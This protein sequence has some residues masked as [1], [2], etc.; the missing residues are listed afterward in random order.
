MGSLPGGLSLRAEL[1][2]L[3]V[4]R[5]SVRIVLRVGSSKILDRV[6]CLSIGLA[7]HVCATE[8]LLARGSKSRFDL[9]EFAA[10]SRVALL[11]GSSA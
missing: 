1:A 4:P 3:S 11:L 7:W 5:E 10:L 8:P 9:A 2:N 6:E